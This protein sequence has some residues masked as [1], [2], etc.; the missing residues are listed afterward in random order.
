MAG[1]FGDVSLFSF[2]IMKNISAFFG[3]ALA[4]SNKDLRDFADTKIKSYKNFP[5]LLYL[6][7]ILLYVMLKILLSKYVYNYFFFYVIKFAHLKDIKFI[8]KLIYPSFK[9]KKKDVI[10]NSYY[11]KISNMSIKIINKI[12]FDK[13]NLEHSTNRKNN[14]MTYY[15][16]LKNNKNIIVFPLND[17]DF[18]NFLDFPILV[19]Q[20]K[21]LI[22]YL[23]NNKIEIRS[24]FYS[25][26]E[27]ILDEKNCLNSEYFEK[28][29]ICLP[30][31]PGIS[32]KK[33]QEICKLINNFF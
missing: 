12:L 21:E 3:G 6:K 23:F 24:H 33:I 14:N 7:Q 17:I 11:S 22:E 18:Q 32:N 20:K 16:N 4:T 10:P 19:K 31:H 28:N 30:S 15:L 2:G 26:C 8:L 1:S 5:K 27:K 25:N 9:F 13:K 29:I